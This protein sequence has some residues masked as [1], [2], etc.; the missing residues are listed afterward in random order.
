L[1]SGSQSKRSTDGAAVSLS[2]NF[3]RRLETRPTQAG[4]TAAFASLRPLEVFL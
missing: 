2:S 3:L 4:K 1:P